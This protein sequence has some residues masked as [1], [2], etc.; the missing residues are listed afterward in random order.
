MKGLLIFVTT[1]F[2]FVGIFFMLM[3]DINSEK[4]V[5][6]PKAT[7]VNLEAYSGNRGLTMHQIDSVTAKYNYSFTKFNDPTYS[8]QSEEPAKS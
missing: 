6:K 5:S 3:N 8:K 7:K 4:K 2:L 1:A